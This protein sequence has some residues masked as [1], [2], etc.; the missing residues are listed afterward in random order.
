MKIQLYP[1]YPTYSENNSNLSPVLE[2]DPL[3]QKI[4]LF[5]KKPI[6]NQ[7]KKIYNSYIKI[8]QVTNQSLNKKGSIYHVN[9]N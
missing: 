7:N 3:T 6:D 5:F 4:D 9:F 8:N 2:L 1:T